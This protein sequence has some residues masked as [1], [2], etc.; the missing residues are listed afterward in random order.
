MH[1]KGEKNEQKTQIK[2]H[3][4]LFSIIFFNSCFWRSFLS[5]ISLLLSFI[6]PCLL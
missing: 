3:I 2:E 4:F 5:L 6:I 1:E